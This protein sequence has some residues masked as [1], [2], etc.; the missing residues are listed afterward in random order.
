MENR[1]LIIPARFDSKDA[2]AGLRAIEESGHAADD[3]GQAAAAASAQFRKAHESVQAAAQEYLRLTRSVRQAAAT[4]A[5]SAAGGLA[6]GEAVARTGA[7][8]LPGEWLES[9]DGLLAAG[10]RRGGREDGQSSEPGGESRPA[11]PP[12]AKMGGLNLQQGGASMGADLPTGASV[13]PGQGG[14]SEISP[15]GIGES[16]DRGPGGASGPGDGPAR[17]EVARNTANPLQNPAERGDD[18]QAFLAG[19]EILSQ[20]RGSQGSVKDADDPGAGASRGGRIPREA[21]SDYLEWVTGGH[22]GSRGGAGINRSVAPTVPDVEAGMRSTGI[23]PM[24]GEVEARQRVAMSPGGFDLLE[25]IRRARVAPP[26]APAP[27]GSPADGPAMRRE[28][29]WA[30]AS[31]GEQGLGSRFGGASTDAIERLL[32]EQNELIRQ[33]LQRNAHPPI[34]APPPMRGGG[35]R[36]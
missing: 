12:F 30:S 17:P 22:D 32:R 29:G 15:R 4:D 16:M 8:S 26:P 19:R 13:G 28:R 27:D 18:T 33:D 34:A 14:W 36:M 31:S 3:L 6:A 1:E 9:T 24:R 2:A 35:I 11:V 20:V 7:G 21:A 23:E 5:P 10:A 25:G